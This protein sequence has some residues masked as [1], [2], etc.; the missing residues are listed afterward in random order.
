MKK[1]LFAI[2]A[3]TAFAGAA[4]AQSSVTVY[5]I[6][7]VGYGSASQRTA[8]QSATSGTGATLSSTNNN[9][10]VI[11]T[12]ASQFGDSYQSTSRLG[13]RGTE[14]LGG[15]LDAFFTIEAAIQPNAN[16]GT[17]STSGTGNRQLFAGLRQKGV[18]EF[19]LGTQY[20]TIFKA[21][22][23][24]D[25]GQ[26]NNMMGNVIYDKMVAS[27][28]RAGT[29]VATASSA[30]TYTLGSQAFAGNQDNTSFTVRNNNM[31]SV[32]TANLAGFV[33]NA[34]YAM[35]GSTTNASTVATTSSGYTGGNSQNSG[36]GVGVNYTWQ[37]LLLTANYQAFTSKQPYTMNNSTGMVTAGSESNYGY[38]GGVS[39]SGTNVKDNQQYYAATYDF[40]IL[41][42]YAQYV[43]RKVTPLVGEADPL[44]NRTAQQLGV[45][46]NFTPKIE[47]WASGG[48]GKVNY[49]DT[50]PA[51]FSG[52]QLGSSY[53]LSKRTNLYAIYGSQQT[54]NARVTSSNMTSYNASSYAVGVRH[55]F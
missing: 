8:N 20:T 36:Y 4:Q 24:T 42:A 41:K 27:A 38:Y 48:N 47:A 21:A 13:F 17:F 7:D 3:V 44:L 35:N 37:K 14:A 26:F 55:T 2:A 53:R 40:G 6:V 16:S 30:T 31:L 32:A 22:A 45:R 33:G 5:G 12:N 39:T 25:P 28:T 9:T 34:F 10:G 49:Y 43:A 18:G 29:T 11:N 54:S 19:S 50:N 51:N 52:Y 46:G 1:S 15:G 23:A